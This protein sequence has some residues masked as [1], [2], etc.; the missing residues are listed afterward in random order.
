MKTKLRLRLEDNS[1]RII[2][3]DN[4]EKKDDRIKVAILS[5]RYPKWTSFQ[6]LN[7]DKNARPKE[8]E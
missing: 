7:E 8:G 5:D 2:E 4:F 6:I 3:I 1:E